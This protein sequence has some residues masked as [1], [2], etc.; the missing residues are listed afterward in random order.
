MMEG[1]IPILDSADLKFFKVEVKAYE[2]WV[3][4]DGREYNAEKIIDHINYIFS[5]LSRDHSGRMVDVGDVEKY[6]E[7]AELFLSY[8]IISKTPSLGQYKFNIGE[9][10]SFYETIW[11][12]L[13][14]AK[15]QSN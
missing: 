15:N 10:N 14:R 12:A 8:N 7:L 1:K 13:A 3:K 2:W 6:P 11:N 9:A 4:L 5:S